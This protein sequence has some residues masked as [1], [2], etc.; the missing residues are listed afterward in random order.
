MSNVSERD[1]QSG[2]AQ[3]DVDLDRIGAADVVL[4]L[5]T[6]NNRETVSAAVEA[7]VRALAD[8][9]PGRRVVMVNPDGG[10]RDD[11]AD[12]LRQIVGDRI[13][14]LQVQYPVH[15]VD[16]LSDTLAGVPGRG[17]AA[18]EIFRA[19]RKLRAGACALLDADV[20]SVTPEWIELLTRPLLDGAVDLV[21][22]SYSRL[23]FDGLVNSGIL[24]PF[25]R[26]LY[27]KR[28]RQRSGADLGFSAPLMDFF[29]EH[30]ASGAR[31]DPDP[32]SIE[33]VLTHGFRIGQ[34]FLG[35]RVAPPREV[36]LDL[37]DTLRRVLSRVFDEME[38]A[39]AHWQKVR[40]S[41]AIPLFG[42]G[43][44]IETGPTDLNRKPMIDSFR[45]GCHNL[46]EIWGPVLPP[47]TLLELRRVERRSDGEVRFS[48]EL[49]ARIV[50]DFA[51]AYHLRI[52]ARDHLLQ[53]LTPLYLGWAASFT[54][55]MYDASAM[56]VEDRLERLGLQFEAQKRYLI[57]RWRWP[58]RFNP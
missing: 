50:Y 31:P 16:L 29:L 23:K 32:W 41:E 27:G 4:G 47:A 14:L 38:R 56:E 54:G 13:P 39:V 53:A 25:T 22:P 9:L 17:N 35:S 12:Y 49:W 36:P 28:L 34:C 30:Q 19:A 45:Q 24:S 8:G 3:Q 51:L 15:P 58:D 7:A 48:D 43:P 52:M 6:Y 55:E 1:S 44:E 26:A 11:T 57:S 40:G 46:M 21:V 10:S 5:P 33:P 18:L 37:S 2:T 20:K 42:P